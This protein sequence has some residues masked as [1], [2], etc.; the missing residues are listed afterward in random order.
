M[1]DDVSTRM[2]YKCT[3]CGNIEDPKKM[4]QQDP[5][6]CGKRMEL[7]P[8]TT[9]EKDPAWAEHARSF[10]EDEPCDPGIGGLQEEK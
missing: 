4:E 5:T 7:T 10:E 1:T 8:I 3:E 2:V 9:C 6:C